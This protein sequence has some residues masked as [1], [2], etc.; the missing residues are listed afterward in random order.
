[1]LKSITCAA[2]A[3]ASLCAFAQSDTWMN[4]HMSKDGIY[5]S[6]SDLLANPPSATKNTVSYGDMRW[7]VMHQAD[8]LNGADRYNLYSMLEIAPGDV[9]NSLLQALYNLRSETYLARHDLVAQAVAQDEQMAMSP[10]PGY[11]YFFAQSTP[12]G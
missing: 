7:N 8:W 1:M 5:Y 9:S 12:S 3:L 6:D 4:K 10:A 11:T 2:M